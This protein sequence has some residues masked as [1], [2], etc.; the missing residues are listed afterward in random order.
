MLC[1]ALQQRAAAW[2]RAAP[3][4]L[5]SRGLALLSPARPA[6]VLQLT[7]LKAML[8][9][10]GELRTV[11]GFLTRPEEGRFAIEDLS[12]RVPVD[13]SEAERTHGLF[14]GGAGLPRGLCCCAI[15]ACAGPRLHAL[16]S[17]AVAAGRAR[18]ASTVLYCSRGTEGRGAV[19]RGGCKNTARP[20]APSNGSS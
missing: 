12:A 4:G 8:G 20:A 7:E 15:V 17:G 19:Q 18:C 13:L 5:P 10:G 6:T 11:A 3:Q 14:T 2:G 1:G 16:C 9:V